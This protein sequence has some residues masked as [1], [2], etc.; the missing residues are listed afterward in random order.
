MKKLSFTRKVSYVFKA[1]VSIGTLQAIKLALTLF[2]ERDVYLRPKG[3]QHPFLVRA[4]HSDPR[5]VVTIFLQKQY[6]TPYKDK[7]KLIID[8]GG[9]IGYSA[10][11][12]AQ[13]YPEATIVVL[14]PDITN[15]KI[16]LKNVA[17]YPN[18]LPLNQGVWWRKARLAVT[19]PNSASWGVQFAEANKGVEA[20]TIGSLLETYG[21]GKHTMI[22]M[23]IEGAE[24]DIFEKDT[25]WISNIL[26]IQLEIHNCWKTVFDALL[27]YNYKGS[28]SGETILIDLATNHPP[29][30]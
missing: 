23:D 15:Y 25:G 10:I 30:T 6:Q 9:N 27:S 16:L 19:N 11:F 29:L 21:Q 24:K 20:V 4:N 2:L 26:A 3:Y 12:F 1:V 18:I 22:K 8:L 17:P 14:E 7:I 28:L 13:Q 5:L